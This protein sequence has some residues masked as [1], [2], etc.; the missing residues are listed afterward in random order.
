MTR[1]NQREI[2][3]Q[4]AANREGKSKKAT[5]GDPI[6]RR[7]NDAKALQDKIAAKQAAKAS[8]SNSDAGGSGSG[9]GS[10]SGGGGGDKKK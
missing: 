9:S 7:E 4:R 10:N 6:K 1:G 5:E 3:R 8:N 2:D